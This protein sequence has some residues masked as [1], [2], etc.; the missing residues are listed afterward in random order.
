MIFIGSPVMRL[1]FPSLSF[2]MSP[3]SVINLFWAKV[4]SEVTVT[5]EIVCT[6]GA[7]D[8]G[9]HSLRLALIGNTLG[10]VG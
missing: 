7:L 3:N 8:I 4:A 10:K 2:I 5:F 1:F 9:C 6:E